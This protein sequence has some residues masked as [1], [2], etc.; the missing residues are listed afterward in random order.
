MNTSSRVA[1]Q[2]AA[3]MKDEIKARMNEISDAELDARYTKV[4]AHPATLNLLTETMSEL[5]LKKFVEK[6]VN[7]K[8]VELEIVLESID[9]NVVLGE[10]QE[11]AYRATGHLSD[12]K[13]HL[14]LVF[15]F[16]L[17]MINFLQVK[18]VLL[19]KQKEQ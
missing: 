12:K 6:N 17:I 2:Y 5:A 9:E 1:E 11:L 18:S 14:Y 16:I 7:G 19:I 4:V 3:Q 15:L 10:V 13:Y 8:T